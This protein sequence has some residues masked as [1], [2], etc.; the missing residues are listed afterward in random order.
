[1]RPC[2][3]GRYDS[4]C[5]AAVEETQRTANPPKIATA[6]V[7]AVSTQRGT[8]GMGAASYLQGWCRRRRS[9]RCSIGLRRGCR[10]M[11]C[12]A[13][14][15]KSAAAT[16]EIPSKGCL[17]KNQSQIKPIGTSVQHKKRLIGFVNVARIC[18][19]TAYSQPHA[20]ILAVKRFPGKCN[21][22][23]CDAHLAVSHPNLRICLG[24]PPRLTRPSPRSPCRW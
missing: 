24:P 15:R 2:E 11:R 10:K 1:M 20:S 12:H 6:P 8:D 22:W 5:D 7:V 17:M 4:S 19:T 21:P 3:K 18:L 13:V 14:M 9:L 16:S 23:K